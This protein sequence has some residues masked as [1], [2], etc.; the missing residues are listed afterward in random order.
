MKKTE[1][2]LTDY[3]RE[4]YCTECYSVCGSPCTVWRKAAL[5]C[6]EAQKKEGEA[7]D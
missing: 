4:E 7:D 3:E 1:D 2:F 5:R 6:I